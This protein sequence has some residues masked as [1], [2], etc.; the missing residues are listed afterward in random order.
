[1]K[2]C[3]TNEWK[4][5]GVRVL[6]VNDKKT[7]DRDFRVG[8]LHSNVVS[9]VFPLEVCKEKLNE[10]MSAWGG[11]VYYV[12]FLLFL[13]SKDSMTVIFQGQREGKWDL[14]V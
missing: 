11:R 1:M 6:F 10:G 2:Q 3:R 14:R 9:S 7:D 4:W 5:Q 13:R 12:G 8:S